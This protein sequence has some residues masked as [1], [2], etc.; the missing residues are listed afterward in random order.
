MSDRSVILNLHRIEAA[1]QFIEDNEGLDKIL[2]KINRL[3]KFMKES[4]NINAVIARYDELENKLFMLK[5]FF[6]LEEA[7]KYLNV[8]KRQLYYL[9]ATN[10]LPHYK[11][12]GKLIFIQR[13]ELHK[14]LLKHKILS[15]EEIATL[16]A[17]RVYRMS[18]KN[19]PSRL[20]LRTKK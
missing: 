11:P 2:A 3:E 16:A 4:K 13:E 9:T 1:R 14:W 12:N 15:E 5:D 10:Q 7:A 18:V 19:K 17:D 20:S 8:S 6:T